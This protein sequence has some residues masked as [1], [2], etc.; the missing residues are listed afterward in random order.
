METNFRPLNLGEILDRTAQLYRTNFVLFAG[1][2]APF[3]GVSLVI[4]L[5]TMGMKGFTP[6]GPVSWGAQIFGWM[7]VL[8]LL[9]LG[10]VAGA[11]NNQA[12]AWVQ[13]GQ[14]AT[15]VQAYRSVLPRLGRYLGIGALKLLLAWTPVLLLYAAFHAS[16]LHLVL[17]GVLPQPGQAPTPQ[18]TVNSD[19]LFFGVL[20]IGFFIVLWPLMIYSV[21]MALRYAL[22]IP[23]SVVENLKIRVAMR[24]GV[25]L[26][27]GA[28]GR[29]LVLWLLVIVVEFMAVGIT[30]SFF[31]VNSLRHHFQVSMGL[32]VLQQLIVFGTNTLVMPILA[33]GTMLFYYDQR[34]RKEG[35]DIEWM[36]A[37]AGLVPALETVSASRFDVGSLDISA[38]G[39]LE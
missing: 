7:S 30:Q 23:A 14:P 32:R 2:A 17:K 24:R 20:S 29:M 4:N 6:G 16:Y 33:I 34:V 11:A 8:V 13:M 27:K 10:N 22:A 12:V 9:I 19:L 36:M 37:A 21:F 5:A 28:R 1:I 35:Y 38:P 31:I 3:A 26:S 15:I 18:T 25:W 39:E